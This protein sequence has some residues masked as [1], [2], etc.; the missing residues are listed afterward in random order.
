MKIIINCCYGGW[1]MSKE[2]FEK[3]KNVKKITDDYISDYDESFR[4]DPDL[5]AIV[6]ELGE[7]ASS[8]LCANLCIVEIPDIYSYSVDEYDG[9]ESIRLH[10]KESYLRELIQNGA[11]E[12]EIVNYVMNAN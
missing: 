6:E 8:G 7:K 10:V 1:S 2:A 11:S 5:I 12:G 3:L 4:D 9:Y